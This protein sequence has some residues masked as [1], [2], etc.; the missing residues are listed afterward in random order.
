MTDPVG[1]PGSGVSSVF[2]ALARLRHAPGVHP[3]RVGFAGQLVVGIVN[4][5]LPKGD[6]SADIQLSKGAGTPGG[7]PDVLGI[8]LRIRPSGDPWD[9]L[10]STAGHG[11]LSRWI[12]VPSPDW[13]AVR[14][15]SLAPYEVAG[16]PWWLTLTPTDGSAGHA[17]LTGL[18]TQWPSRFTLSISGADANWLEIGT[19]NLLSPRAEVHTFDPVL[20]HPPGA[21]PGPPWLRQLRELAYQGS[22]HGRGDG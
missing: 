3:Q 7:W 19:V 5:L 6:H 9:F 13:N 8:A 12:P 2:S 22:R 1:L 14:Y 17:S 16:R 11:R 4:A 15:S 20:N 10:F 21:L 18:H